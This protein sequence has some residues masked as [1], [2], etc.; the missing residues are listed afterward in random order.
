MIPVMCRVRHDP[1]N[2]YGDCLRACVASILEIEPPEQV[3]HIFEDGEGDEAAKFARLTAYLETIG[4]AP[5]WT[6]FP[7]DAPLQSVLD[8]MAH[9]NPGCHYILYAATEEN[10]H[11]VVCKG[12][13]IVH[14][15]AW[16]KR[17][18]CKPNSGGAW[19]VL[20]FVPLKLRG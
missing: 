11:V 12:S 18:I 1:P 8:T 9:N 16:S 19:G 17:K 20:T 4:L 6:L 15:P 7:G 2:S 14:D 5:F 13:E 10:N 3:P